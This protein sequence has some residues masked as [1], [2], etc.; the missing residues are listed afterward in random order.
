MSRKLLFLVGVIALSA[1]SCKKDKTTKAENLPEVVNPPVTPVT[2]PTEAALA[3][4]VGFFLDDWQA[5][6]FTA[7]AFAEIAKPTAAA[8]VNVTVDYS[9]TLTKVSKYLFGTNANTYI[10]QMVNEPILINHL[11]NLSPNVIRF[12]GGNLSSIYFFNATNGVN[13]AD[14]P[15]KLYDTNGNPV[16]AG[17]WYG[18]NT[19]SWT[20][21]LENY[22]AMLQQ[23]NT[24]GIITVNYGYARYGTSAHPDQ[25]AA[26]LAA[27]WVRADRGRTKFWEIGNESS[28]PWQAGWKIDVRLNKDGQ[29]EIIDGET[30]GKHFKVFADSMRKAAVE[31]GAQIKIGAQ[32]VQHDPVSSWNMVDRT[33]NTGYFKQA[34]NDADFYIVHDYYTPLGENTNA[35]TILNSPVGISKSMMD[36][37]KTTTQRAG[38]P[39]KP[40]ALTEWNIGAEGS[41]QMVSH[42]AGIHAV[43]VLGELIKNQFGMASRWDI[44]NGYNYGNDH[45]MFSLGDEGNGV[46]K[47]SPRPAFYYQ[48]FFQRFTGDRMVNSTVSGT[49]D[50][51][52]YASG[53]S[54]GEAGIVLVNKG[55]NAQV[56]NVSINNFNAG[57][58]YYYYVLTGGTDNGEF[59]GK[60]LINDN[61][62]EGAAG[63]PLTYQ[64]LLARSVAISGGINITLPPRSVVFVAAE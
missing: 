27:D 32:L 17:Y 53:F 42:V 43:M 46:A 35:V 34:G 11:K 63:G 31:V 30:Y 40:I 4:S 29:P 38:V 51:L 21:S 59:S 22:Y 55:T 57:K 19:E 62:P 16:D 61:G 47:W 5:R 13:P 50:V 8:T 12:P 7:P 26:H 37:M 64:T 6:T 24:K 28:G 3:A 54:S 10:G 39:L 25:V 33:W 58:R 1:S 20:L 45:G 2:P 23:T 18:K 44:A 60:V 48:Y 52:C 9:K 56:T 14:A 15:G 41:K 49:E 36:W